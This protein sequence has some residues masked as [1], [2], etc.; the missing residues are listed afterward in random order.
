MA[1][2]QRT[3]LRFLSVMVMIAVAAAPEEAGDARDDEQDR[4]CDVHEPPRKN[5]DLGKKE[6]ETDENRENGN[7]PAPR[8]PAFLIVLR[9]ALG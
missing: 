6:L 7:R 8:A 5:P 4:P 9:T 2:L 3:N 1:F